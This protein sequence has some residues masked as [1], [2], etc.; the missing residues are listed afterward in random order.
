MG[1]ARG[2]RMGFTTNGLICLVPGDAQVGDCLSIFNG[3]QIPFVLRKDANNAQVGQAPITFMGLPIPSF[4]A[5]GQEMFRFGWLVL[6][7]RD[8][9]ST[10]FK[11]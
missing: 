5:Q 11:W 4:F 1:I 9:G 2:R 6:Y 3:F 7:S 8:D 10:G